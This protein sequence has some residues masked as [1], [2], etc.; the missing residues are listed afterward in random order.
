MNDQSLSIAQLSN[1]AAALPTD[2]PALKLVEILADYE[3][4][5]TLLFTNNQISGEVELISCYYASYLIALLLVD[6]LCI[7]QYLQCCQTIANKR[8]LGMK[9]VI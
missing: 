2:V 4:E 3:A 6:D 7:F 1:L 9:H 8:H 5:V